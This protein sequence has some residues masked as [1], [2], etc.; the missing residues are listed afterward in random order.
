MEDSV[1]AR[2][3]RSRSRRRKILDSKSFDDVTDDVIDDV[4]NFF[5]GVDGSS[6]G[7]RREKSDCGLHIKTYSY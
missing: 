2:L 5:E 3:T 4:T 6:K 1:P 7:K